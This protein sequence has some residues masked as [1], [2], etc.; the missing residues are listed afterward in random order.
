MLWKRIV[1]GLFLLLAV[2][3]FMV[4]LFVACAVLA[5]ESTLTQEQYP[6]MQH[7]TDALLIASLALQATAGW[8]IER[9]LRIPKT[10]L[11]RSLRL[12]GLILACIVCSFAI[13][14]AGLTFK[15]N[16]WY[17]LAESFV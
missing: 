7:A 12:A 16:W 5:S 8:L 4:P 17:R 9:G 3:V 15:E 11:I 10:K 13:G 1:L 14:S 6:R 2:S